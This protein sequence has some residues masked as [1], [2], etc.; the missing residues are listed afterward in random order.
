MSS[1]KLNIEKELDKKKVQLRRGILELCVMSIISEGEIYSSDII[2]QLK[3]HSELELKEG[4]LYP[5]LMRLKNSG[6]LHYNW[7]ESK[8][9]PPR[10]YYHITDS[11][12]EFLAGLLAT[13]HNLVKAVDNSTKNLMNQKE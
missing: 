2:V 12:R 3:E 11:G 13:W 9:G 8:T 10:K 5:L 7:R 6:L 1:E 4:T